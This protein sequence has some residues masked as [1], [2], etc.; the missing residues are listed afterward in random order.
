ML[1]Y[2]QKS[3]LFYCLSLLLFF[4]VK[5]QVPNTENGWKLPANGDLRVIMFFVEIDYDVTPSKDPHPK[6]HETWGVGEMPK[7]KDEV[8]DF[9]K[10]DGNGRMTS[11][12]DYMSFGNYMMYGDYYPE[13]IKLKQSDIKSISS[14]SGTYKAVM[15][16]IQEYSEFKTSKSTDYSDFDSWRINVA[17]GMPKVKEANEKFDHV[18]I[19]LRNAVAYPNGS[20][21]VTASSIG[22]LFGKGSDSF[23]VFGGGAAFP[24]NILRHEYSHML[25]GGNNFHC[26]GGQHHSGGYNHFIPF[27]GG[28]SML[29]GYNSSFQTCNA[30]DRDR[31]GWKPADKKY[32]ISALNNQGEEVSTAIEAHDSMESIEL[33]LR[34]FITSGDAVQIKLP[35]LSDGEYTQYIWL[36]NH[37]TTS[38][39][40][41]EF[42]R[43]Q[44]DDKDCVPDAVPGVYMY[45]QVGHDVKTGNDIFRGY[46]DYLRNI[47]A[48]GFY[49]IVFEDTLVQNN[50]CVNNKK[51]YPYSKKRSMENALTGSGDQ[52]EVAWDAGNDG[53]IGKQDGRR[54]VIENRLGQYYNELA[55][56][57]NPRHAFTP[58]G[59]NLIGIGTNPSFSSMRTLTSFDKDRED[60]MNN[61][62]IVLNGLEVKLLEQLPD[63]GIKIKIS[64]NKTRI[65]ENRRWAAPEIVL[66]QITGEDSYSLILSKKRKL[67]I[68][69]GYT[70][71]YV[72]STIE[73]GG[74][75]YFVSPTS[76]TIRS[77]AKVKLEKKSKLIIEKGSTVIF[78]KGSVL[79]TK[80]KVKIIVSDGSILKL[81]EEFRNS[82]LSK[83]IKVKNGGKV[84]YY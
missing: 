18:M 65:K 83:R 54:L 73:M 23:S 7:W 63:G 49:D 82:K 69:Q 1:T 60:K 66:P 76:W 72:D 5:G 21:N 45:L 71:A 17:A 4:T 81:P 41:C 64:F 6:G 53:K 78:E 79:V 24:F 38:R 27:Q 3:Y 30:W 50:W 75:N 15:R 28:W 35:Y 58:H 16:K 12:F 61:E 32:T 48:D 44:Y 29:G 77:G 25:F 26:G 67:R 8:F 31:L 68:T 36:E 40:A 10:E 56:L 46:G 57:G 39:N 33:V 13:L 22:E 47:P 80:R 84:V 51:Y 2:K 11:Y 42:D 62:A 43:F 14:R 59:N 52:E 37:Q 55:T 9:K 20:G 70:A 34:D 74:E 19:I